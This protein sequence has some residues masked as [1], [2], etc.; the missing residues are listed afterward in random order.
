M[1]REPILYQFTFFRL[2]DATVSAYAVLI[3]LSVGYPPV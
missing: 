2:C 3:N 1:G